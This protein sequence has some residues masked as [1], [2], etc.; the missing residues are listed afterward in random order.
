MADVN[1]YFGRGGGGCG[2]RRKEAAT[3]A[4]MAVEHT[5]AAHG[6][7]WARG[8]GRVAGWRLR[9][10]GAIVCTIPPPNPHLTLYYLSNPIMMWEKTRKRKSIET[11]G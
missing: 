6:A 1:R 7:I 10:L 9:R 5:Q 2:A 8:G 11:Y 4:I 3:V